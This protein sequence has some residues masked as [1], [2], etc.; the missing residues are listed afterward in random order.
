MAASQHWHVFTCFS[1]AD[2]AECDSLLLGPYPKSK[3]ES[4]LA[5]ASDWRGLADTVAEYIVGQMPFCHEIQG[6]LHV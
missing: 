6:P 5:I 3:Y 2:A 1:H 4:S